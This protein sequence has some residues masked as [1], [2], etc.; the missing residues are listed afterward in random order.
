MGSPLV[1]RL[2]NLRQFRIFISLSVQTYIFSCKNK[3]SESLN[4]EFYIMTCKY[5]CFVVL[6]HERRL[7]PPYAIDSDVRNWV[8]QCGIDRHDVTGLD[9]V[10]ICG[11]ASD[12]SEQIPQSRHDSLIVAILVILA[13]CVPRN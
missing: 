13:P 6:R 8:K 7:F 4:A 12:Q 10:T 3:L 2:G 11:T 5:C 1:N 9:M